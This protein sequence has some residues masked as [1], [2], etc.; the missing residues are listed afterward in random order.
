VRNKGR[1]R[2][3]QRTGTG[4]LL[5]LALAAVAFSLAQT[6]LLPGIGRL[7]RD[8]NAS[9]ADVSWVM[10]GYLVSAAILTPVF[11]RLGDMLGKKPMLIVVLALFGLGSVMAALASGIWV[12]VAAR[13]LQGAAG[14]VFPLCMGIINDTFPAERRPGALGLISATAGIG[15]GGGLLMGGLLI[16]RASWH[17]I[18]W[19]GT[20]ISAVA[21]LGALRLPGGGPRTPGRIDVPGVLLLA[22]G[23]TA[24]LLAL[25]RASAW[26]WGDVRILGLFAAGLALLTVFVFVE[27][28]MAEPLVDMRV[29]GRPAVLVTNATT[30]LFGFGLF[31]AFT[32]I[33]QLAQA[34]KA[35]GYGFGLDATSAGV[36]LLP[37]SLAMLLAGGVSGRL[38]RRF[39]AKV[40]LTAGALIAAAGLAGL[41]LEHGSWGAVTALAML[42]FTGVGLGVAAIPNLIIDAVPQHKTGEGTGVNTLVRS[43]GSSLGSQVVAT[44]LAGSVTAAHTVPTG[45]AYTQAFWIGAAAITVAAV[46]AA[47][48]PRA[49]LPALDPW[50]TPSGPADRRPGGVVRPGVVGPS[51]RPSRR[52]GRRPTG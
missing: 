18:F 26:G 27:R 22:A 43:V 35:T 41:A 3:A 14:G 34:P 33:P 25:T 8:L 47:A 1:H 10:S 39:G 5:V 50:R 49:P 12:V 29:L 52:S 21:A 2:P 31:G 37:G 17:W 7:G 15:A 13:A 16:D 45:G 48:I 6:A 32:L 44:L 28:R 42:V 51:S 4:G 11:G 9:T 36:L 23:L 38:T 24:P 30:L 20:I 40:P 19:A 46:A